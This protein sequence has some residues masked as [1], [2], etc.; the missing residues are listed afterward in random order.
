MLVR[1]IRRTIDRFD[2]VSSG[3]RVIVGVS[4]GIDSMVLLHL[5][6]A[7]SGRFAL[8]LVVAHVNH[9]LRPEESER[10]LELVQREAGRLGHPFEYAYFNVMAFAKQRGLSLQDAGRRLRFSFFRDLLIKHRARKVALG[11]NADDQ[12]ETVLLRLI[13]GAGLKGLKGILPV[14]E[15][16]VIR[17]LLETWRRE[18]EFFARD[19]GIP[20]LT[21]S[22]NLKET[23]LRNRVRLKLIPFIENGFQPDF[24]EVVLKSSSILREEDDYIES[25][26]REAYEKIVQ[27]EAEQV[28]FRYSDFQSLHAALK[29][30]LIQRMLKALLPEQA[31]AEGEFTEVARI[32]TALNRKS[33]SFVIGLSRGLCLEKRYDEVLLRKGKAEQTPPFEVELAFSGRTLIEAIGKEAVVEVMPGEQSGGDSALHPE[34]ALFD[35]DEL[36]FP[37]TIRSLRPGDRFRPLGAGGTQKL[38][39]FFID[40]KVPRFERGRIPLLI[41]GGRVIW[42]VGHRIDERV[43]VTEKTR[44]ILKVEVRTEGDEGEAVPS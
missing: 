4:G 30:R 34:T 8:S 24:K 10:E 18:I 9:G 19:K 36:Q 6:N 25:G 7:F 32:S 43:K 44:R 2:L 33:A 26:A 15:G 5:L 35:F 22:S 13:R 38:K 28:S 14:R 29:W 23:Y 31:G 12:V 16:I 1:R 39:E 3:D 21:D 17:P 11:Q 37:L 42:V 40:H 27:G 41:S 20:Y